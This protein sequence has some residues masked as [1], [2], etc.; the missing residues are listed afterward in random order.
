MPDSA[1]TFGLSGTPQD[2]AAAQTKACAL[3]YIVTAALIDAALCTC[4]RAAGRTTAVTVIVALLWPPNE[5][6]AIA[7]KIKYFFMLK[8]L[9]VLKPCFFFEI[10]IRPQFGCVE[11][12]SH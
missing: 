3:G 10:S 4:N 2:P 5:S 1:M 6:P 11:G 9:F 8:P 7:A 12:A